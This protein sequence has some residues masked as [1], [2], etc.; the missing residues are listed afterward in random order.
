MLP[1][2]GNEAAI[3]PLHFSAASLISSNRFRKQGVGV[4]FALGSP[5]A[6]RPISFNRIG[7][8]RTRSLGL[9]RRPVPSALPRAAR[10]R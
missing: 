2:V 8:R 6:W 10:C 1:G 4:N 3:V 9:A 5:T 7:T